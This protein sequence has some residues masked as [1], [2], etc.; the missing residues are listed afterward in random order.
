MTITSGGGRS[1]LTNCI[2]YTI[3]CISFCQIPSHYHYIHM[4]IICGSPGKMDRK[5]EK[6]LG[7]VSNSLLIGRSSQSILQ[8]KICF[9]QIVLTFRF[10]QLEIRISK[11]HT[12]KFLAFRIDFTNAS[13]SDVHTCIKV[14]TSFQ[15][16]S[17]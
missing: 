6:R 17:F 8:S 10:F 11:Y 7:L 16:S 1:V 12:F 5:Y 13:L 4:Q 2:C 9:I 14:Y 15:F 3:F